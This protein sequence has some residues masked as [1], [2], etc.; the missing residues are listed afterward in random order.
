MR[1]ERVLEQ[2]TQRRSATGSL[3]ANVE[4]RGSGDSPRAI[5][6]S[7][8]GDVAV[9]AYDGTISERDAS[10]LTRDLLQALVPS[11]RKQTTQQLTCVVADFAFDGGVGQAGTLVLD[12]SDI[13]VVGSGS[14]D[15]RRE[16]LALKL[17]PQP[18]KP[19]L[20]ST[21]AT[22]SVTGPLADPQVRADTASLFASAGK[23]VFHNVARLS[24]T[25]YVAQLLRR[26]GAS[27][28]PCAA[29]F[30]SSR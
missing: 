14:I 20:L 2:F 17:V 25:K 27:A 21:A 10:L 3:E 9:F 28:G 12:A 18:R 15:L 11:R 5:A 26:G 4:L 24:G 29:L 1:L 7:L 19:G 30:R 23:A 13:V 22:V 16:S 6:S 8:A